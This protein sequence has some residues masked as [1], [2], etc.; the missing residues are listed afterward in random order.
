MACYIWPKKFSGHRGQVWSE[1]YGFSQDEK[2]VSRAVSGR[3]PTPPHLGK[4]AGRVEGGEANTAPSFPAARGQ[5]AAGL[6]WR[7]EKCFSF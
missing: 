6:E 7:R 2:P 4:V 3:L 5:S 1:R